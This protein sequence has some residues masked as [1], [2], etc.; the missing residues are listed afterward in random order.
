LVDG[1]QHRR[2]GGGLLL[3]RYFNVQFFVD[4]NDG[5][6]RLCSLN[7]RDGHGLVRHEWPRYFKRRDHQWWEYGRWLPH[8]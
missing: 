6:Y 5:D 2:G 3:V 1:R 7:E 8:D 4:R